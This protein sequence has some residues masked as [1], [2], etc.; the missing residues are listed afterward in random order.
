LRRAVPGDGTIGKSRYLAGLQCE[1]RLW[2]QLFRPELATAPDAGD[3]S[4]RVEGEKVGR[5]ARALYPGGAA[6]ES[7]DWD[8]ALADTA[9]LLGDSSVPA[10]YEAAFERDDLRVR[11]DILRRR[12]DSG[13]AL[14]EVK[15]ST[16]VRGEHIDDVAFQLFVLEGS[17]ISARPAEVLHLDADYV[18]GEGEIDWTCLFRRTDVTARALDRVEDVRAD[19]ARLCPIRGRSEAPGIEPSE[20][21][22]RPRWCEF[23]EHCTRN[24]PLDWIGRFPGLTAARLVSLQQQGIERVADLP[25]DF[26]LTPLQKRVRDALAGGIDVV[27]PDLTHA[28]ARLGPPSLYLDFES[29]GP[30][31]PPYPGTR[32]FQQIPFQ[33]S[34][35]LEAADGSL[36]HREFL[37]SGREDPRR[38]FARSLL[39]AL[40]ETDHPILVYSSFESERL[41]DLARDLPDLAGEIESVQARLRDLY[42][43]VRQHVYHPAF[44][45]SFSLKRIAPVLVPCFGYDDLRGV[46][47]GGGAVAALERM[48]SGALGLEEESRLR[49]A[50]LA[51]CERDTLALVEVHRALRG[52]AGVS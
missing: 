6:V 5:R 45:G 37:A 34:L 12:P 3:M 28:L 23:W 15:S 47:D 46:T 21:C 2:L 40:G 29:Y 8:E 50:L 14:H 44:R 38:A 10:I 16:R 30:A 7:A 20:H 49:G 19:L 43:I 36:T 48:V 31:L 24:K 9:R 33:W 35:H 22:R 4:R 32:P 25:V 26:P 52:R 13:W 51:Y 39:D 41:D 27:A 18:R 1:R 11:T 17:G 42:A